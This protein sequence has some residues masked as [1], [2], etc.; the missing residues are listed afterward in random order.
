M[1]NFA[2]K[3]KYFTRQLRK[4]LPHLRHILQ[5][6]KR[7]FTRSLTNSLKCMTFHDNARDC[8]SASVASMNAVA[9]CVIVSAGPG[10]VVVISV[11]SE[12]LSAPTPAA[13]S[14]L[15]VSSSAA[16]ECATGGWTPCSKS[17]LNCRSCCR[18]WACV[19]CRTCHF[20]AR[21]AGICACACVCVCACEGDLG[22]GGED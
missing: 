17:A 8:S 10:A 7:A 1:S 13:G 5:A 20:L 6:I 3:T 19:S 9:V 14:E 11:P 16:A 2:P 4:I 18:N 12:T 21:A 15:G 22:V